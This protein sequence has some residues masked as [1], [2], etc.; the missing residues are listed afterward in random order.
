MIFTRNNLK[1]SGVVT[2]GGFDG[3]HLGH[4][5][6]LKQT[7]VCARQLGLSATVITFEPQPKEYFGIS[8]VRLTT[9]SEKLLLFKSLGIDQVVCLHF[10]EQFA[11]LT[12]DDFIQK[13][14]L[15]KLD[16]HHVIAGED[17][18]F[19]CKQSGDIKQLQQHGARNFIVDVVPDLLIDGILVKSTAI[20]KALVSGDCAAAAR[21]L[22]RPY[23]II[24]RV[25]HGDRRG[26]L[27][28]FPTANIYLSINVAPLRGVYAARVYV[29]ETPF[30]GSANI[31]FRPTVGGGK[32]VLEVN[33]LDFDRDIYGKRIRIEFIHKIRDEKKFTSLELLRQQIVEDVKQVKLLL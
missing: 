33:L 19:G 21:L 3:V 8:K 10:D 31:G 5:Q 1:N 13:I 9:W 26:R 4:Q 16:V 15:E 22:G 12:A 29:D 28:G 18:R 2:I 24:G 25:A 14:L 30:W 27:L 6:L 23:T 20:R 11:N 7:V 32:H 17:F